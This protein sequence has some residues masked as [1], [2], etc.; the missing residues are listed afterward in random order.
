MSKYELTMGKNV[1]LK[2][3]Q[4]KTLQSPVMPANFILRMMFW[5]MDFYYGKERTLP[6]FKVV[7]LLARY[8]YMA[9]E[10]H[11]YHALTRHYS[12]WRPVKKQTSDRHIELIDLGRRSQDNEQWHLMI[13]EDLMRQQCLTQCWWKNILLPNIVAINY[14][15]FCK[16]LYFF[17]K[18]LAFSMNARFESHAEHE[19]MKMVAE[20]PEWEHTPV[21]S[22]YFQ[23]YPEQKTLADLFRRIGL[24]E[25]D[26]MF[27][28]MEQYEKVTG[29]ELK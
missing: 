13:I 25:R 10:N 26:H 23:Y 19:Y 8:P 18:K 20:H 1:D 6:K 17:S 7:E 16:I 12:C 21:A 2:K 9:W 22:A 5:A 3:E 4:E 11:S 28:S 27:E 29:R 15:V 24:D 14:H